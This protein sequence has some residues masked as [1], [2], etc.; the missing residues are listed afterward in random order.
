VVTD[1]TSEGDV[2]D[3]SVTTLNGSLSTTVHVHKL[4]ALRP[5]LNQLLAKSF[6][7]N[8][9]SLQGRV[10]FER[11]DSKDAGSTVDDVDVEVLDS[12]SDVTEHKF[13]ASSDKSGTAGQGTEDIDD[14]GI[15]GCLPLGSTKALHCLVDNRDV[16]S[17]GVVMF[18]LEEVSN[19]TSQEMLSNLPEPARYGIDGEKHQWCT[20]H[21]KPNGR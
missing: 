14:E 8:D 18:E 13:F 15:K 9:N 4:D 21:H 2:H 11:D 5:V 6:T 17:L 20:A 7:G 16:P 12:S 19:V 3:T 10:V 1:D